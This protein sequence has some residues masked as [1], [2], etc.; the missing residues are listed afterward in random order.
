MSGKAAWAHQKK[1]LSVMSHAKELGATP[2]SPGSPGSKRKK[3]NARGKKGGED[4]VVKTRFD[5][6]KQIDP[7]PKTGKMSEAMIK[8]FPHDV[9]I[10][11]AERKQRTKQKDKETGLFMEEDWP[12]LYREC[13]SDEG[14]SKIRVRWVDAKESEKRFQYHTGLYSFNTN[15]RVTI[16]MTMDNPKIAAKGCVPATKR[17]FSSTFP[18]CMR[19]SKTRSEPF[20]FRKDIRLIEGKFGSTI[21]SY[22]LFAR[23]LFTLNLVIAIFWGYFVNFQWLQSYSSPTYMAD[24]WPESNLTESGHDDASR[25]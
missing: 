7:Q 21:A 17:W 11:L 14:S 9:Q 15:V 4:G 8:T 10:G 18:C 6:Q 24:Y 25:A 13:Y 5:Y 22:F 19:A 23:Q 3:K 20:L 12:P 2:G 16:A 1:K